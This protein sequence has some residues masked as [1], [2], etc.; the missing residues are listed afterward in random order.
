MKVNLKMNFLMVME[1]GIKKMVV[2]YKDNIFKKK[3]IL[4]IKLMI[5]F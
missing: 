3:I 4:I 5:G 1:N 2:I